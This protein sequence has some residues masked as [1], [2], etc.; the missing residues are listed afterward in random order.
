[1]ND[2]MIV[3]WTDQ[4]PTR[5]V[6]PIPCKYDWQY[7]DLDRNSGRDD[8]GKMHRERVGSKTKL[9]LSWNPTRDRKRTQEMVRILKSLPPFCWVEYPDPD[10]N[11]YSMKCY[12]GDIKASMYRYDPVTG[13]IW[14]D[15]ATTFTEQ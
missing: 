12:R 10:G 8:Y 5:H 9:T 15:Y 7:S 1:M 3:L 6:L 14:K 13:D 2:E 11:R 4:D